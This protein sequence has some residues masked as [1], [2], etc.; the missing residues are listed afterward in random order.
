MICSTAIRCETRCRF[1]YTT[2]KCSGCK[3]YSR[4]KLTGNICT[5][6]KSTKPCDLVRNNKK[7]RN[8]D[9]YKDRYRY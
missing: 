3:Y 7:S 1:Y 2:M 4:S 5:C 8:K 6:F 9:K